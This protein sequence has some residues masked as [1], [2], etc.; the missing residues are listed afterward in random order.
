LRDKAI[1]KVGAGENAKIGAVKTQIKRLE[2][3]KSQIPGSGGSGGGDGSRGFKLVKVEDS[4]GESSTETYW[5]KIVKPELTE[6][7]AYATAGGVKAEVP[8]KLSDYTSASIEQQINQIINKLIDLAEKLKKEEEES[9][10]E[11]APG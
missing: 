1:E 10:L 2:D 8:D 5:K 11:K 4:G 9:A 6:A 7:A 3:M